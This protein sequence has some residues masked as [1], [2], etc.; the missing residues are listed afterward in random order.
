MPNITISIDED[1]LKAGR[2]Y[3]KEHS[4]SM[5]ALIRKLLEQTVVTQS[6]TR[7][8]ECFGLMDRAEGNSKGRR[9]KR[10]DLYDV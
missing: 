8:Y 10:E 9:W 4:T 6:K 3:A 7:L 2:Q 5:N 1:L